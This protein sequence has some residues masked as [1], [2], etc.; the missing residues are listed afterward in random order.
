[1]KSGIFGKSLF[2]VFLV[3]FFAGISFGSDWPQWRGINRGGQSAETGL[4]KKWPDDGPKLKWF[5]EG[6]GEGH[7]SVSVCNGTIY[8]TGNKEKIEHITAMDLDGNIKWQKPYGPAWN[9]SHPPARSCPTI[10]GGMAYVVTGK[11]VASCFD[12]KS[13]EKKWTTDA[14]TQYEGQYGHWGIADSPLVVD[15]KVICTPGGEKATMVALDKKTGEV[16]WAS[17]SIGDKPS[18][19][20]PILVERGGKKIIVEIIAKHIIGVD[21]ANGDI[22]WSYDIKEYQG[23]KP[24]GISCVSPIYHDGGIYVTSGY[25]MGSIKLVL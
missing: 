25:G 9:R 1:M 6:I 7:S 2:F 22:L 11:G 10:N 16:V 4:L 24:K 3:L 21:A 5:T 18:Y 23:P 17:K 15:D 8:T 14:F 19:C 20:S 12:A 13:G